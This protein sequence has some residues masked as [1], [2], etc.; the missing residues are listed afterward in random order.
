VAIVTRGP[1]RGDEDATIR[2]DAPLGVILS[3]ILQDLQE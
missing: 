3:R 2:L 1:S